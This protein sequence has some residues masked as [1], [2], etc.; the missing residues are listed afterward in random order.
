MLDLISNVRL[1]TAVRK[2]VWV[3]TRQIWGLAT[4][5]LAMA[6]IYVESFVQ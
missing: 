2:Y 6:T 5:N 4:V 1:T 3:N